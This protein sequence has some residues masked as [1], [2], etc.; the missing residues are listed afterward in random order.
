MFAVGRSTNDVRLLQT[1]C[2]F[3]GFRRRADETFSSSEIL[4]SVTGCL[5]NV[6]RPSSG[7]Y[8]QESQYPVRRMTFQKNIDPIVIV[9]GKGFPLQASSGCWGFRRLKLLDL[10]NFG[11]MKAVRSSPLRTGRL[12]PQEYPGTHF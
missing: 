12:Y 10:L 6:S 8:P 9:K 11:T 7:P 1:T 5:S 3:S 4:L 2:T